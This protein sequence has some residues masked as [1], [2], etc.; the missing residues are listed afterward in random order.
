MKSYY[1]NMN[2]Q[3]SGEHEVHKDG[4]GWMP[5][6]HNRKHLGMFSNCKEAVKEAKSNFKNT[7]AAKDF[8][9][10]KI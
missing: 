5:E 6:T 1:A 3:P 9:E 4:C 8:M 7:V 10:I 2:A